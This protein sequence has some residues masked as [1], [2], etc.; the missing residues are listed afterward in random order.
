MQGVETAKA[1]GAKLLCT[2]F[3]RI[4]KLYRF[5]ANLIVEYRLRISPF[6]VGVARDFISHGVA[7]DDLDF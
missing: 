4:S 5:I 1:E 3:D 2:G 7:A 6:F